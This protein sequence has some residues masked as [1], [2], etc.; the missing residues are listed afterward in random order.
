[1]STHSKYV[2]GYFLQKQ[3]KKTAIWIIQIA[4]AVLLG[5]VCA[6]MFGQR[7]VVTESSMEPT[8]QP[9]D[10]IFINVAAYKLSSPKRGD[11]IAFKNGSKDDSGLNIRRIIGLP[12][13]TIQIVDGQILI[14]GTVY[15]E[16][17]GFETITNPGTAG[18]PVVIGS[19]EYFV[20]GDNRNNS[21]DSR[22][23]DIGLIKEENIVGKLWLRYSPSDSFGLVG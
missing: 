7:V 6:Y 20:L 5:F 9:G 13:E 15:E 10:K 22:H 1:M 16:E 21:E 12:G 3:I 23:L 14:D 19:N 17:E 18:E 4:A 8:I 11:I 2:R